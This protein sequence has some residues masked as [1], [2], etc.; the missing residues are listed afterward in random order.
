[1][2]ALCGFY[3]RFLTKINLLH[4]FWVWDVLCMCAEDWLCFGHTRLHHRPAPHTDSIRLLAH[5]PTVPEWIRSDRMGLK[6]IWAGSRL[7]YL[8][9]DDIRSHLLGIWLFSKYLRGLSGGRKFMTSVVRI[10]MYVCVCRAV[11]TRENPVTLQ[12]R[13]SEFINYMWHM[14]DKLS[15]LL[16]DS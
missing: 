8:F 7:W 6:L 16:P 10:C 1:M 13:A 4:V 3:A 12:L 11:H 9:S 15:Q 5:H 2:A 14:F